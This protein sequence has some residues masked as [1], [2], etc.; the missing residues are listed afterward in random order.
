MSDPEKQ[1]KEV[2][3][4]AGSM[5]ELVALYFKTLVE[6]GVPEQYA[7]QISSAFSGHILDAKTNNKEE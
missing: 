1:A 3:W 7:A 6:N 2:I 5:A 4:A